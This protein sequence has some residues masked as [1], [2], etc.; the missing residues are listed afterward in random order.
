MHSF[1]FLHRHCL[2]TRVEDY[3]GTL[4]DDAK[5]ADEYSPDPEAGYK[6]TAPRSS[7]DD[8][9]GCS[10]RFSE[11]DLVEEF[12]KAIS[13]K[14]CDDDQSTYW[15]SSSDAVC[16]APRTAGS[17]NEDDDSRRQQDSDA[18]PDENAREEPSFS[19]AASKVQILLPTYAELC[20]QPIKDGPIKV[21]VG[22]VP[23]RL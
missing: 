12:N 16:S 18:D 7:M 14:L 1:P 19:E 21:N 15:T 23:V 3:T 8:A 10:W 5:D 11:D 4:E 20:E 13:K 2:C 6:H 17:N 9:V 22:L